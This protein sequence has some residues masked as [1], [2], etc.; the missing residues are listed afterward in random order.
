M[1]EAIFRRGLKNTFE[2][3]GKKTR[4]IDKEK[5][6]PLYIVTDESI[7]TRSNTGDLTGVKEELFGFFENHL[8]NF[9]ENLFFIKTFNLEEGSIVENFAEFGAWFNGKFMKVPSINKR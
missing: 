5:N 4:T 7:K 1:I 6:W 9:I 3:V 8:S 2:I